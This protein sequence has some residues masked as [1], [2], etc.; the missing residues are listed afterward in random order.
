VRRARRARRVGG[1]EGEKW[2]WEKDKEDEED[3]GNGKD[4]RIRKTGGMYA[5]VRQE[6][7]LK[8][9]DGRR[10]MRDRRQGGAAD[11]GRWVQRT[12]RN[13]LL[14]HV[15]VERVATCRCNM[16][17]TEPAVRN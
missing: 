3:E 6:R 17:L 8:T 15:E 5:G 14:E 16:P 9:G 2:A 10:D 1:R 13:L 4:L 7:S 11:W 12:R